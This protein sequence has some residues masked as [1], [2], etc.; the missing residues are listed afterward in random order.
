M[1]IKLYGKK[2]VCLLLT[3]ILLLQLTAC[4]NVQS[5]R[6]AQTGRETENDGPAEKGGAIA[7]QAADLMKGVKAGAVSGKKTD[8]D[9][10]LAMA[11]FAVKLFQNRMLAEG[12]KEGENVLISPLSVMLALA[13][14]A[15]G[16]KGE[17]RTQMETLLG[18][19]LSIEELNE[20][21]YTYVNSLPSEEDSELR[22]AN[23][24]WFR[25]RADFVA[26]QAFL[27]RNADYYAA[28]AR[29]E[30]FDE[31]TVNNINQWVE[32]NTDGLIKKVLGEIPADAV[33]YLINALVFD[34]K[35]EVEYNRS[36]IRDRTFTAWDGTQREVPMMSS[37]ESLYLDDG[38]AVGFIK[39]YVGNQYSF[40]ALLPNEGVDINDYMASMTGDRLVRTIN[41]AKEEAVV[42]KLPK[43]SC[44]DQTL[45][46]REL[47]ELG[48]PLA[49]DAGAADLSGLGVSSA[50]NLYI[51]QVLHKTFI[52]VDEL[53]TKAGAVT[54]VEA[55]ATGSIPPA[56]EVYYVTLDRPFVYMI[57]DNA[58]GLPMFIGAVM[59]ISE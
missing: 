30:P 40:A 58:T 54:V 38:D 50:G 26:D 22:I 16:A 6:Y 44:E 42:A 25:D 31:T 8:A 29:K 13:M 20:Y 35:W 51:S 18:G 47:E 43:F 41:S 12:E 59:E 19:D 9:F 46:K 57:V 15:N 36:D 11:D 7:A 3:G 23:S 27:Q 4:G 21:L 37:E 32:E 28:E 56:E 53:G 24:I 52:A 2:M 48:M 55:D 1:R 49:F 14:T 39:P 45:M 17:T 34:A 33:M 10:V 5:G